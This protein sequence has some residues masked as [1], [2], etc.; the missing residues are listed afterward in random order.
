M[1]ELRTQGGLTWV[2]E[3]RFS[4]FY[5]LNQALKSRYDELRLFKFPPKR[6]F[7]SFATA[8]V[9]Q[10]RRVF[11]VYLQE[12]LC[13]QPRPTGAC[14]APHGTCRRSASE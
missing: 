5:Q 3:R 4:Q 2:V 9:E 13:L 1:I 11:E 12:L 8:T 7:S 10:R 6:W 14:A